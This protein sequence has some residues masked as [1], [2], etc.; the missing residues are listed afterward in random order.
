M[1][2]FTY[3]DQTQEDELH[4]LRLLN[5]EEKPFKRITKRLLSPTS[6]IN[7]PSSLPTSLPDTTTSTTTDADTSSLQYALDRHRQFREDVLLDFALFDNSI[8]RIQFLHTSNAAERQRYATEKLKIQD[9]AQSV[10]ANTTL[11]RTALESARS[12]LAQRKKYDELAE[13]ITNN[14]L[15]RPR[16]EQALSLRKLEEECRELEREKEAY[17]I[18]WR[19]RG[20]QFE[21]IVGEGEQMRRLIRDEK[22][23]VERKE[24]MEGGDEEGEGEGGEGGSKGGQTPKGRSESGAATPMVEGGRTPGVGSEVGDE[25]GD[26]EM[27]GEKDVGVVEKDEGMNVGDTPMVD[28]D[29]AEV[30][31]EVQA[32]VEQVGETDTMD[33]T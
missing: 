31:D 32:V 21:R 10:R 23:E 11:L 22:E 16:D 5:V 7:L 18:T 28:T 4:K 27:N 24:G 3:L 6:L 19:E 17:A 26:G 15:L 2:P 1:A 12:T 9:T 13:R 8:E 30:R 14:R 33:T 25:A 20:E 29:V